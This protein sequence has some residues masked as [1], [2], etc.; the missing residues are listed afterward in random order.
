MVPNIVLSA[1]IPV[2]GLDRNKESLDYI[3]SNSKKENLELIIV[4]DEIEELESKKMKLFLEKYSLNNAKLVVGKF[5]CPGLAR[6]AGLI[7]ASGD[8]IT[9][10]D[11]DDFP[12]VEKI[13]DAI[14]R[15][16]SRILIGNYLKQNIDKIT[17]PKSQRILL[18]RRLKIFWLCLELGLWRIVFS[19]D[20]LKNQHFSSIKMGE[21]QAFFFRLE[22][23]IEDIEFSNEIFYTYRVHSNGSL[24]SSRNVI[25]EIE[26]NV[27]DMI[28]ELPNQDLFN[29]ILSALGI[30]RQTLTI[31]KSVSFVRGIQVLSIFPRYF[32]KIVLR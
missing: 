9:F 18:P 10:W 26:M 14:S 22:K 8:W 23:R 28:M 11:A 17:L 12:E 13:M 21:D 25:N 16:K 30:F 5:N 27:V 1:I 19:A 4:L 20:L 24:T 2:R 6:N 31:M 7:H 15:A 29:F 32:V 3:F